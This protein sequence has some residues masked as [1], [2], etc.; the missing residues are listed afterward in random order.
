[1]WQLEFEQL[2]SAPC[3]S[4]GANGANTSGSASDFLAEPTS[5]IAEATE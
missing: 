5:G 3:L 4:T 1:V 2:L